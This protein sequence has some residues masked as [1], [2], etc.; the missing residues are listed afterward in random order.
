MKPPLINLPKPRSFESVQGFL[1][2]LAETNAYPAIEW[3]QR[4]D[5]LPAHLHDSV[6]TAI[7]G[8]IP[9]WLSEFKAPAV[10]PPGF[11]RKFCLGLRARCCVACLVTAPY[12]QAIWEHRLYV[13]CHL[14]GLELVDTCPACR[15]KLCWKRASMMRCLCGSE[16]SSWE[17]AEAS[18]SSVDAARQ[19][20]R[21]FVKAIDAQKDAGKPQTTAIDNLCLASVASLISHLG[22]TTDTTEYMLSPKAWRNL[23]LSETS[24]LIS[25]AYSRLTDWPLNFHAFLRE[26]ERSIEDVVA[27]S[28]RMHRLKKFLFHN[29]PPDLNFLLDG[30]RGYMRDE[31]M[32]TLDR[33]CGWA[34]DSDIQSH[35]YVAAT[36]AARQLGIRAATL[37]A[38]AVRVG[39]TEVRKPGGIRRNFT[40]IERTALSSLKQELSDE[41]SLRK[42]SLLL[43]IS[44]SRVEQL[45]DLGLLKRRTVTH[46][47]VSTSLFRRSSALELID[48]LKDGACVV[49]HPGRQIS[50][51]DVSK[52]FLSQRAEFVSLIRAVQEQRINLSRWDESARGVAGAIFGRGEFL[53]WHRQQCCIGGVT[54][55]EAAAHLDVKQ[56]V[57]YHFVRSGLLKGRA[58][59]RGRRT[60]I[61]ITTDALSEFE[62]RFVSSVELAAAMSLSVSKVVAV[63]SDFGVSPIC[64]PRTDGSRQNMFRRGDVALVSGALEA[65]RK[66]YVG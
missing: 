47:L 53:D 29:L 63:L 44:T 14:H 17:Q 39:V 3:L 9:K 4:F 21:A 46:G 20:W 19:I 23:T 38:L 45:A 1:L 22:A 42:I 18:H 64:G 8:F 32:G 16:I 43:G 30:F 37:H 59:V 41:I 11:D 25:V 57:A 62:Q 33:R 52:Y 6:G 35:A 2:R 50:F 51:A 10:V 40:L 48:S 36:V 12:W 58:A 13:A 60:V 66:S 56:E 55:P 61:L 54:V 65:G 34:T 24:R 27:T 31:S 5:G 7:F 49:V 15:S 26:E 28:P